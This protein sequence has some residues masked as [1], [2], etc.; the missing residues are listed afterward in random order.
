MTDSVYV[1]GQGV[2]QR[3]PAGIKLAALALTGATLMW[4]Q[5]WLILLLALILMLGLVAWSGVTF[6]RIWQQVRLLGWFMLVLGTYSA[7]VQSPVIAA[8]M[9]LRLSTLILAAQL[10]SMTT[11]ITQM[12]SVIQYLLTPLDRL[13]WVSAERVSLACGLT[14][15]LIPELGLQWHD[16]REAQAAR[17]LKPGVLS[18][19][20]PMLLRTIRRAEE[21]AEAIDARS[22]CR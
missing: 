19:L 7:L 2:L 5:Q 16:I 4:V 10:V 18:M 21:I 20:V 15:R 13:G 8:E 12:M 11:P 14:L 3:L 17:G 22:I 6:R 1:Q 9:L